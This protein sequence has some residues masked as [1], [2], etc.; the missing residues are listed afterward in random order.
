ML[1]YF[2]ICKPRSRS[3][4][5]R[6]VFAGMRK[7]CDR[8]EPSLVVIVIASTALLRGRPARARRGA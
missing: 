1:L 6:H 7:K 5:I 2:R 3:A 4:E 8:Q